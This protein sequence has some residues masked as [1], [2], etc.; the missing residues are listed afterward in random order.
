MSGSG[1]TLYVLLNDERVLSFEQNKS[2]Y[3]YFAKHII[4]NVVNG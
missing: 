3:G 4:K 2:E 1:T